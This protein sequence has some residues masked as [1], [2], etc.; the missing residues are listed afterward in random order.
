MLALNFVDC[1]MGNSDE[2]DKKFFDKNKFCF[3]K[4]T[5]FPILSVRLHK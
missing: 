1:R 5:K 4:F 3:K 2:I